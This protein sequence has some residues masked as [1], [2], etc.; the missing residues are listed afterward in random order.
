MEGNNNIKVKLIN[1]KNIIEKNY[2]I[3]P[4]IER[5]T[6]N[7]IEDYKEDEINVKKKLNS[8]I[9]KLIKISNFLNNSSNFWFKSI[10]K[11][12]KQ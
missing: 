4:I 12:N 10:I 6:K 9:N 3:L 5:S 1:Q 11:N 2:L 7:S 8:K